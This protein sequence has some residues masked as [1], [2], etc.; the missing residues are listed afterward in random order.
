[1]V[2][3]LLTP[4]I[5]TRQRNYTAESNTTRIVLDVGTVANIIIICKLPECS[6]NTG[7]PGYQLSEK[8]LRYLMIQAST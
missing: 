6:S 2:W 1:M 8:L 3:S 5:C 4:S 7:C